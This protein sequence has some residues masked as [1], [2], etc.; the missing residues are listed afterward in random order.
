MLH[1]SPGAPA[2]TLPNILCLY[3]CFP[4]LASPISAILSVELKIAF[5]FSVGP[6]KHGDHALLNVLYKLR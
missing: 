3:T 4:I 5:T 2:K 6:A 1:L